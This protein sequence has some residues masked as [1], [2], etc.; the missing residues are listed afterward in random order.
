MH[1]SLCNLFIRYKKGN[2]KSFISTICS[3]Y[4]FK[5]QSLLYIEIQSF[6]KAVGLQLTCVIEH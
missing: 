5:T 2:E 3:Q 4:F 6:S 1:N